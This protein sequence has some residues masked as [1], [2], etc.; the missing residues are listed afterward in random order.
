VKGS[1]IMITL[2]KYEQQVIL[3]CK[4]WGEW[5]KIDRIEAI[6]VI[7]GDLWGLDIKQIRITGIY[8]YMLKLCIKII[9]NERILNYIF[10]A[11]NMFQDSWTGE[12]LEKID[13]VHL[14]KKFISE[15]SLINISEFEELEPDYEILNKGFKEEFTYA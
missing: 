6:K 12:R 1:E 14:I 10:N 8:N 13:L 5:A 2:D 4:N 7:L 11:D 3:A 9:G 15:L